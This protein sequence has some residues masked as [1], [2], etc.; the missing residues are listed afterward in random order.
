MPLDATEPRLLP[1]GSAADNML[2]A[3]LVE[4]KEAA[5]PA[6]GMLAGLDGSQTDG[7]FEEEPSDFSVMRLNVPLRKS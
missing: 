1:E 6:A 4:A 7:V 3:A 2:A 5:Q